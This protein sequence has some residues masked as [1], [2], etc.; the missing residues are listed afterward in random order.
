MSNTPKSASEKTFQENFVRELQRYK[1]EAPDFLNG[2]KQKVTVA[3]LVNHWRS[4]LNR[5]NADQLEGVELTDSEFSQ[6]MSKVHQISNSYEAAKILAI[7]ESKGKIDGIYRDDNPII[8]RKQIASER[9]MAGIITNPVPGVIQLASNTHIRRISHGRK[10]RH[11]LRFSVFCKVKY[12]SMRILLA[13]I[14]TSPQENF[15]LI[16]PKKR[17]SHLHTK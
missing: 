6:V 10:N 7:E 17:P 8:T 12:A 14:K 4:E 9:L 11:E 5:I 15:I 13:C 16:Q 2:N 3:D 1:W